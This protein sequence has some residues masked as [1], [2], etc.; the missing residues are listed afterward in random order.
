MK[1]IA[2]LCLTLAVLLGSAGVSWSADFQKGIDAYQRGDYAAALIELTP[3]AEQ[4]NAG[5][6]YVLGVMY[7][8]GQ[9]VP[10]DDQTAVKW[11]TLAAE[12]GQADAQYALG[13]MY[14]NGD[15]V[16]QDDQAAVK[17]WTLA[18]EQG[19]AV[20]QFFLG[21]MYF[22]GDGVPEDNVYA[23]MWANIAAANGNEDGGRLRDDVA[24]IMTPADITAAQTLARECIAK[25]YKGC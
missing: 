19:K 23:H 9:G 8:L 15:G 6:Q 10:E 7:D 20:A 13:D 18:A 14:R 1:R 21:L 25:N 24:K 22:L 2:T 3:L 17:W 5:A 11:W 16:P 12:Q 4:G